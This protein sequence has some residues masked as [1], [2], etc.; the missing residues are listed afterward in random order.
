M[1]DRRLSATVA[2]SLPFL[3]PEDHTID[4]LKKHGEPTCLFKAQLLRG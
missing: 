4:E 3:G 2:I 1:A